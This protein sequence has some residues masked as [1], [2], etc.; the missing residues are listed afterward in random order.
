V[1]KRVICINRRVHVHPTTE[2]TDEMIRGV[3][4]TDVR[5]V[6]HDLQFNGERAG[7]D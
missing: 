5:L 7:H 6:R 2:I 4:G 3:Y 1:V